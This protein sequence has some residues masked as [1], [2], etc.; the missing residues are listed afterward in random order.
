MED[1]AWHATEDGTPQGG[2]VSPLL[3]NI[4]LNELDQFI[5]AKWEGLSSHEKYYRQG[6]QH[7]RCFIVRYADDFVALVKGTMKEAERLKADIADFLDRELHLE[8]SAEKT[9]VTPV[10]KGIDFLGFHIRKY[11]G[12]TLITP[13]QRAMSTFRQKVKQRVW[14]G[15]STHNDA[16][17]VEHINRYLVGWAMYYAG[18]AAPEPLSDWTTTY[19][20][21]CGRPRAA[22]RTK[23]CHRG[24]TT[25]LTIFLID[26]T[27]AQRTADIRDETLVAGL[28]KPTP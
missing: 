4:Y 13:S 25:K 9:L 20:G 21:E 6:T 16:S 27:F 24:S 8:L 23:S 10:D 11:Q 12:A 17:A 7:T 28:T 19:G 14:E 15:F 5:Y 2:I 1:E 26:T 22:S 3:A 18:S